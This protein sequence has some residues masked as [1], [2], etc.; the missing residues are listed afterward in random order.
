[1]DYTELVDI[2]RQ[3]KNN[4]LQSLEET[5]QYRKLCN[6]VLTAARSDKENWLKKKCQERE[7]RNLGKNGHKMYKFI[8]K[9]NGTGNRSKKS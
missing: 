1:M 8:K 3:L 6:D 5:N 4:G 9:L 7:R 2:K